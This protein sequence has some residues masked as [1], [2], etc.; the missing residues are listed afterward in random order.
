MRSCWFTALDIFVI[1]FGMFRSENVKH[2]SNR[3]N[4]ETEN[5]LITSINLG[6]GHVETG[7]RLCLSGSSDRATLLWQGTEPIAK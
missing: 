1:R 3:K 7:F 6:F 5:L 4:E 2:K